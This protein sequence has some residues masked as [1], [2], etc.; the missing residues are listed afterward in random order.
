MPTPPI[1]ENAIPE[2]P[3]V[4]DLEGEVAIARHVSVLEEGQIDDTLSNDQYRKFHAA[5]ATGIGQ[6]KS[7]RECDIHEKQFT[8]T[9]FEPN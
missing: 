8:S 4:I 5:C 3:P 9:I 1:E 6:P 7:E 2:A